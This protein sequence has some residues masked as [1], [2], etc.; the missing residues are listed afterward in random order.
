MS[1]YRLKDSTYWW[2]SINC[3]R[4]GRRFRKS[5][6]LRDKG[7]AEAF[8]KQLMASLVLGE[9]HYALG[10]PKVYTWQDAADRWLMEAKHKRD[11]GND[12]YK[13]E[14]FKVI[15]KGLTL[16]QITA[17][18]L[19][20]FANTKAKETSPTTANRHLGLVKSILRKAEREWGWIS[21]QPFV[22]SFPEPKRRIRF[23][24]R[25]EVGK[26]MPLLPEHLRAMALFS[27]STGLRASNVTNLTWQQVDLERNHLWIHPDQAKAGRAISVP[28]NSEA[29]SVLQKQVGK[30]PQY[31]FAFKGKRIMRPNHETWRRAVKNA[32]IEDFR[33]HDLRHTFASWHIQAGTP[34]HILQELGGWATYEMVKRYA[35]L[36]S[37]AL[38]KYAH[39]STVGTQG[40]APW[41]GELVTVFIYTPKYNFKKTFR[42]N[43]RP[44]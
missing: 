37:E 34:L 28:L 21:H 2:V 25:E 30:H 1:L 31:V 35:H 26:L 23:L 33:W 16:D 22:P 18:L 9:G 4:T 3:P 27:L 44:P 38:G 6:K 29:I 24:T 8:E 32:G 12:V 40:D 7:L 17:D 43:P 11:F 36:T 15:F 10:K 5:T 42:K 41:G 39:N 20:D 19:R 14:A 13:L